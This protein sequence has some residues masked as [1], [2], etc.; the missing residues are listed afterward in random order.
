MLP[1]FLIAAIISIGLYFWND[2]YTGGK[3]KDAFANRPLYQKC[4]EVTSASAF[5]FLTLLLLIIN[6]YG[7]DPTAITSL[8]AFISWIVVVGLSSS[9]YG[10]QHVCGTSGLA[11]IILYVFVP[12]FIVLLRFIDVDN[13]IYAAGLGGLA[14][15][16]TSSIFYTS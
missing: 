6:V 12:V 3:K 2:S 4:P 7:G 15:V 1:L 5:F 13:S 10:K 16:V 11:A 9:V 8:I 14:A